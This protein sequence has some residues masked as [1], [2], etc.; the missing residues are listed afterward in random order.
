MK[1]YKAT[2]EDIKKIVE[3]LKEHELKPDEDGLLTIECPEGT[4]INCET[5][6]KGVDFLSKY[7]DPFYHDSVGT[8]ELG[9]V[10]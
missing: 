5:I 2:C 6:K 9:E 7:N 8:E 3:I 10:I 1:K 4:L